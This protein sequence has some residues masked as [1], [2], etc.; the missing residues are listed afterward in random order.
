M[1]K[2]F[3]IVIL[4]SVTG[5]LFA[6]NKIIFFVKDSMTSEKLAGVS[7]IVR[8]LEHGFITD[9]SGRCFNKIPMV[10]SVS[11]LEYWLYN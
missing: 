11:I 10:H 8:S 5:H 4:L 1:K 6:Q 3:I 9:T 2:A 7:V